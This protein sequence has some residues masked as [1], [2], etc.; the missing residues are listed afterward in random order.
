MATV[1]CLEG[2]EVGRRFVCEGFTGTILYVGT[3]PPTKG[4]IRGKV[5]LD[6]LFQVHVYYA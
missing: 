3:V 4:E 1:D 5:I 6:K 2:C